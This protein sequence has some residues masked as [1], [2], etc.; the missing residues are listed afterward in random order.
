MRDA[1]V[2]YIEGIRSALLS[3]HGGIA[4]SN[5]EQGMHPAP[6]SMADTEARDPQYAPHVVSAQSIAAQLIEVGGDHVTAFVKTITNP[7]ETIAGWTCIRSML[8]PCALVGWL[9]DSRID[10]RERTARTFAYRFEGIDQQIKYLRVVG[11]RAAEIQSLEDRLDQLES[12]ALKLGYDRQRDKNKKRNGIARKMESATVVIRDMLD[13]ESAYRLMSAVAHGH[14][15][16]IHQLAFGK[17]TLPKG[18][19]NGVPVTYLEKRLLPVGVGYL[20]TIAAES[21]STAISHQYEYFGSDANRITSLRNA[22][23]ETLKRPPPQTG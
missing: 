20:A 23:I 5:C 15:W 2:K 17:T 16:A 13:C 9:L 19:V 11:A 6:G 4:A 22:A 12:E 10:I 7:V 1:E 8:E 18:D 3:L 21:L 14:S